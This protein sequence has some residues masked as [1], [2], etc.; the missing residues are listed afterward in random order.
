MTAITAFNAE[1]GLNNASVVSRKTFRNG[2]RDSIFL[3][4]QRLGTRKDKNV[5]LNADWK[6]ML[7]F[8]FAKSLNSLFNLTKR[9]IKQ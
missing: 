2:K 3:T 1:N 6:S 5:D 8:L 4:R 9:T 7:K